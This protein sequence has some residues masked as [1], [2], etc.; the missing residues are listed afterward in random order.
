M[1]VG[2]Y[3][4]DNVIVRPNLGQLTCQVGHC[5]PFNVLESRTQLQAVCEYESLN[6]RRREKNLLPPGDRSRISRLTVGDANA[7]PVLAL[8][9]VLALRAV[10]HTLQSCC[11]VTNQAELQR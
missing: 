9:T 10:T 7:W 11:A 6:E 1:E 8:R 4:C 5:P 2:E 3:C